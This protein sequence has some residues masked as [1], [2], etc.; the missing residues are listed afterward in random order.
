M[1]KKTFGGNFQ[2]EFFADGGISIDYYDEY[3]LNSWTENPD[4]DKHAKVQENAEHPR[5]T[6]LIILNEPAVMTQESVTVHGMVQSY[7]S[8][9][10]F[11]DDGVRYQIRAGLPQEEMMRIAESL[12]LQESD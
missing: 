8:L 5:A 12:I 7:N 1:M 4:Y 2:F 3:V 11:L 10:V 9:Q 6:S